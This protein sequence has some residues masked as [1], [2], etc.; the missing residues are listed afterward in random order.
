MTNHQILWLQIPIYNAFLMQQSKRNDNL[1]DVELCRFLI[2][3]GNFPQQVKQ[4][5][6]PDVLHD[7]MN[8]LLILKH[9]IHLTQEWTI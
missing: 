7:K 9:M 5:P 3:P 1:C 6:T 8:S 4:F 2:K